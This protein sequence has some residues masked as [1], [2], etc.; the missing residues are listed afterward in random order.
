MKIKQIL[1]AGTLLIS[2]ASFSQK[3]ELKALKKVYTKEVP[4]AGDVADY[5]VNLSK[6]ESVA[7]EEADKVYLSFYKSVLPFVEVQSLGTNSTTAQI[8]KYLTTT[9]IP[10]LVAGMNEILE[11]EKK[12]GKKVFTDKVNQDIQ[13]VK[14][15]LLNAAVSFGDAKKY[16]EASE[17]LY[18]L[19]NLDK[20]DQEKLY[21][22]ANYAINDKDY[23][24]ALNYYYQLK[25][26]NF[27]GEGTMYYATN[28]QTKKEEYFGTTPVQRDLMIKTSQ[29]EKPREEKI[30]SKK[31]EIY[32]NIALILVQQGKVA[33]AKAAVADARK[34][35]PDDVSLI[36][37][38]A[39]FALKDKDYTSYSKIVNEALL[40]EPNNVQLVFNLGV[41]SADSGK[42]EDAEK[43]YKQS[44]EID[45]KY[46]EAY[47]NL[48]ELKL[49]ADKGFVEEMNKLGTSDSDNKKFEQIRE[50]QKAN[51]RDVLPLLE[52]AVDLKPENEAVKGT[53]LGVY[54][55]LEMTAKYKELKAKQ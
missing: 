21:Y 46:F 50:K 24:K 42:I 43:Y 54:Q 30:L 34:A 45:P 44:L 9:S 27:S 49:R 8:D 32:K 15:M 10:K 2:V 39:E 6:L 38:E 29:Y 22:A 35:N 25:S 51:Y 52:K 4:S 40:K 18:A 12:S 33:E 17:V 5:K 55:A 14:P 3:D 20:T 1:I 41:I 28:K 31:G 26:L 36:I 11:F 48:A 53:L 16:K 13:K 37:T 47:L 7:A 23:E 19:Y